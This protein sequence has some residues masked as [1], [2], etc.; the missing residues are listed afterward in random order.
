MLL[1]QKL[2]SITQKRLQKLLSITQKR[3]QKLL[4]MTI[5]HSHSSQLQ[6]LLQQS[7]S[8]SG[9]K[10]NGLKLLNIQVRKYLVVNVMI[11]D[12]GV[13]M[14]LQC[15]LIRMKLVIMV[16][17]IMLVLLNQLQRL[18]LIIKEFVVVELKKSLTNTQY[19]LV[20]NNQKVFLCSHTGYSFFHVTLIHNS[21]SYMYTSIPVYIYLALML[22][23]FLIQ[24]LCLDIF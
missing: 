24:L 18:L 16:I 10:R 15:G 3:L 23:F 12:S 6:K 1:L 7:T 22:L 20:N 4:R 11:V 17:V 13:K 2:L 19:L 21:N 14:V 9:L 5:S 8:I